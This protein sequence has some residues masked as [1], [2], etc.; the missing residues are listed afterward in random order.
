MR[1][2]MIITSFVLLI[3]LLFSGFLFFGHDSKKKEYIE[4]REYNGAKLG[5]I[6]DFRENSI[7]GVQEI[8]PDTYRLEITGMVANPKSYTLKELDKFSR[9]DKIVELHCVEGWSVKALWEG[10]ELVDLFEIVQPAT[11]VNTVIFY[12]RDGYTTS[13]ELRFIE[14]NNLI[15]AD[16]INGVTLPP[17][18]GFPFQL[19]AQQ[20][21]GYKWIRWIT[22][23]ELTDDGTFRGYWESHGYNN[24][25]D[26]SGPKNEPKWDAD[27]PSTPVFR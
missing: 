14:E 10:I 9:T 23:I 8:D 21:W 12:A 6:E 4:I 1:K 18:T 3:S 25:G 16:K 22:K 19:V 11:T 5:S 26:L 7:K 17:E 27:K 24:I 20:K 15:I 2:K 13:L